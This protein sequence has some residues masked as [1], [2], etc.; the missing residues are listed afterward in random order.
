MCLVKDF[1]KRPT[2]C[3]LLEHAFIRQIRH[4]ERVL[5]KQLMEFI[6]IH[7]QMGIMEKKRHERI[8]TKKGIFR[9]SMTP[10]QNDVDDLAALEVLDENSVT[11]QLQNRYNRDQ[12]YTYVGDILVA[13][14]P[15]R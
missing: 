5:Q 6:D 4:N 11:D 3:D 8:H 12:I 10:N 9:E 15:F 7:Q 1:E 14:N 13:V 2:V